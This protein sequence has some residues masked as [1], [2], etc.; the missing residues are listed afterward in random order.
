MAWERMWLVQSVSHR[1]VQGVPLARLL[2]PTWALVSPQP[3]FLWIR[4]AVGR[5]PWCRK[6]LFCIGSSLI[7]VWVWQVLWV[8]QK[9]QNSSQA[10]GL[11]RPFESSLWVLSE[12]FGEILG[13]LQKKLRDSHPAEVLHWSFSSKAE[14]WPQTKG[15]GILGSSGSLSSCQRTADSQ[16]T[17]L[18]LL[19]R[20]MPPAPVRPP[21]L[22]LGMRAREEIT[23]ALST[24][25]C[26]QA[27][28]PLYA[29]IGW[30][31]SLTS[32]PRGQE[33]SG[34]T[35]ILRNQA[36]ACGG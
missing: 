34:A 12:G 6:Y 18:G 14:P 17:H 2:A 26:P 1:P 20:S 22:V 31:G 25:P 24:R 11:S 28:F 33:G 23:F 19:G 15:R 13:E 3:G 10:L 27:L 5:D 35:S 29:V 8:S 9:G 4:P 32:S 36:V 16:A 30:E 21:Q 7:W